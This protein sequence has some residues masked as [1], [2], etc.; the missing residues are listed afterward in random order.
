MNI[1]LAH[2]PVEAD[3]TEFGYLLMQCM[4]RCHDVEPPGRAVQRLWF[5]ES[6]IIIFHVAVCNAA[7][8]WKF[9]SGKLSVL[10]LV[11]YGSDVLN[12]LVL[13]SVGT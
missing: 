9:V 4:L 3:R 1:P 13:S 6:A 2:L 7:L 12:T 5:H 8:S 11:K 10:R